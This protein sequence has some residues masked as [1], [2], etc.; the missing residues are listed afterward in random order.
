MRMM[1]VGEGS[2]PEKQGR[3]NC[4]SLLFALLAAAAV[5]APASLSAQP[6]TARRTDAAIQQQPANNR[7]SAKTNSAIAASAPQTPPAPPPPQWPVNDPP[8]QA[9]V[10]WNAQGLTIDAKNSSLQQI[11][12][13]IS[14]QTGAKIQGLGEDQRVFG[15]YGP[16][17]PGEVLSELLEGSGYNVLMVGDTPRGVPQQIE[18]SERP[19]GG[20]QP[21]APVSP[22]EMYEPPIMPYQPP[23]PI[24]HPNQPAQPPR[25][26]QQILQEMQMRQQQLR[27]E[28]MRQQQQQQQQ[29][30]Q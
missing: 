21:N 27:E 4:N 5:A 16:G 19:E 14:T 3:R 15:V 30:Q 6:S 23:E 24:M 25:T 13:E 29:Q 26:P 2:R 18:L 12:N 8:G 22:G 10:V 28:Q 20:P 1:R 11:L 17:Q 7:A 9:S